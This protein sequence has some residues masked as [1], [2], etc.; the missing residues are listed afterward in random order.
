M[1]K[2]TLQNTLSA[3]IGTEKAIVVVGPRQVGKTT[4][5]KQLLEGVPHLFL[6][7][8]DPVVRD[9][10]D[11][12]STE[13]I[14]QLIGSHKLVFVDEA[15][16]INQIGL[17][18]KIITDQFK[19]VQVI[20][21]GSSAFEIKSLANEPLTGRKWEYNLLPI[22]W[23]ELEDAVGYIKAQQQLNVRLVY[24]MYPEIINHLG[25]ERERLSL[26]ADSY[27][28]KDVLS[29][30]G[31]RKPEVVERLLKALAYQVGSQ[32]SYNEL[33]RTLGIDK[34]TVMS[35]IS[36]LKQ[37]YIIYSLPSFS[38]N[39]RNELKTSQKIY[40]YDNGIRNAVIGNFDPIEARDDKGALWENFLLGERLK[41]NIYS[42]SGADLHFWR[43]TR[44]QEIDAIET[45]GSN[46]CGYE[47][48]WN[49][50][51]KVRIPK[52]FTSEYNSKVQVIDPTNF[53]SFVNPSETD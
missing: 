52:T 36:L 29:L 8:D 22:H 10:L 39:L 3:K 11:G 43:T 17:T 20:L 6:D 35:Y 53:R 15:Q 9:V 24:G 50:E 30:T 25:E 41:H 47:F 51:A 1:I 28:Y 45:R 49:A 23:K 2:R 46:I 5:I 4:L 37:S 38:R 40:F 12:A 13:T 33:S 42:Q 32:V 31:I 21:S 19:D 7:G 48:K 14:R 44:Q 18:A 27:L 26:L 34:K 16:R